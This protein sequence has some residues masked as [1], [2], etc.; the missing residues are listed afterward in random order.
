MDQLEA[1]GKGMDA[2]FGAKK[3]KARGWD[4]RDIPLDD[5]VCEITRNDD[6]ENAVRLCFRLNGRSYEI[7]HDELP[8][9]IRE[10][11]EALA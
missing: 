11:F 6:A 5:A 3:P 8:E 9:V 2:I 7:E 10:A 4:D 1:L